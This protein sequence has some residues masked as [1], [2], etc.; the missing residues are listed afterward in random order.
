MNN[1]TITLSKKELA[2][3]VKNNVVCFGFHALQSDLNLFICATPLGIINAVF[4]NINDTKLTKGLLNHYP[5][6]R[7]A[8][9]EELTQLLQSPTLV[10]T[11]TPFQQKVWQLL[12]TI[13]TGI[14]THYQAVAHALGAPTAYRAVANAIGA[15]NHAWFIPCH[16]VIKKNG[17]LCGYRWGVA[18]KERLLNLEIQL[19]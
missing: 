10:L 2:D 9:P 19:H 11:G 15:N 5:L 18:T 3:H 8:T 1:S 17:S 7:A 16:R 4:C 12:L 13:P 14:T 6:R